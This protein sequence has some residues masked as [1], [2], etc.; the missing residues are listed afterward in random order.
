MRCATQL[1][2]VLNLHDGNFLLRVCGDSM[3]GIGI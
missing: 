3:L 2:D 1:Q